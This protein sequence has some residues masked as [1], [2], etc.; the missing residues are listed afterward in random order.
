MVKA[1]KC[2][3][4]KYTEQDFIKADKEL[5]VLYRKIMGLKEFIWGTVT[6]EGIKSTQKSWIGYRDAWVAFGKLRCSKISAVSWKTL[7]TLERIE[8][9]KEFAHD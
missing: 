9:L 5:N 1:D 3:F 2:G 8:Q 4:K 7:I 6:R